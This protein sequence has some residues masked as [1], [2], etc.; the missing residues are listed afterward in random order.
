MLPKLLSAKALHQRLQ[1]PGDLLLLDVRNEEEFEQAR[2]ETRRTPETVNIPYM[3]FIEDDTRDEAIGRLPRQRPIV[4]ICAHGGS[5]EYVAGILR[6]HGF[7][8]ANLAGGMESWA[9]LHV[10][11]PVAQNEWVEIYQLDRPARGCLSYVIISDGWAAIIDPSHYIHEYKALIA[12]R[13]ATLRLIIDTHAHAD[14]ISGGPALARATG[15][16]YYLHP[17]DAIHPS[18]V[19]PASVVYETLRDGHRFRLGSVILRALHA[20]GHTLGHIALLATTLDGQPY[21]FSGDTLLL[22]SIG[23]PDLGGQ[24][25]VWV[26]L[27]YETIFGTL[28][29]AAPAHAPLLPGHYADPAEADARGLFTATFGELWQD[30]ADLA[31]TEPE[32]FVRHVLAS[33]PPTPP[34]YANIK[35][36]N[37]G[38]ARAD[39]QQALQL[40]IGRNICALTTAY[41]QPVVPVAG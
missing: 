35:R 34:E 20:P 39:A 26:R 33:L 31:F 36:V 18:D 5:S 25:E 9:A 12:A 6:H 40:E 23:R 22:R 4:V 27:A 2:I 28:R 21:L 29:T 8:V 16:P 10:A 11:R 37:I 38:L 1:H 32:A 19:A 13:G 3:M 30:N 17:Y 41:H 7:C 14:H 24:A 15:A